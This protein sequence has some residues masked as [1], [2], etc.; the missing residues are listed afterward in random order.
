MQAALPFPPSAPLDALADT[1]RRGEVATVGRAEVQVAQT[2]H[3]H[4][5][6]CWVVRLTYEGRTV[7]AVAAGSTT[8]PRSM[9]EAVE[10]A[11]QLTHVQPWFVAADALGPVEV[12]QLPGAW[13][14]H[15][16]DGDNTTLA[17]SY[18]ERVAN[19]EWPGLQD[20]IWVEARARPSEKRRG[21]LSYFVDCQ[22]SRP[23]WSRVQFN[24]GRKVESLEEARALALRWLRVARA[25]LEAVAS[26]A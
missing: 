5:T 21:Q 7:D 23:D 15:A 16:A 14:E 2:D 18:A 19:R 12:A 3:F 1:L 26:H 10:Q 6:G 9:E 4:H 22:A 20:G 13:T 25:F 24:M 11:L 8:S 17:L